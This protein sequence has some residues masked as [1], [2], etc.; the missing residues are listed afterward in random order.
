MED[1]Q[2][3]IQENKKSPKIKND[4]FKKSEAFKVASTSE[5]PDLFF[6]EVFNYL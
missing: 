1:I 5:I 4:N 3:I 6:D 2:S